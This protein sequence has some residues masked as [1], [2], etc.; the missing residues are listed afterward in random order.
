MPQEGFPRKEEGLI[1]S[2][3]DLKETDEDERCRPTCVPFYHNAPK[4]QYSKARIRPVT[5][6]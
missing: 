4:H 3:N 1:K 6:A 2:C 5:M